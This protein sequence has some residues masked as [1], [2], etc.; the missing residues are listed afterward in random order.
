[1]GLL[2]LQDTYQLKTKDLANGIV[3]GESVGKGLSGQ[4]CFEVGKAAYNS[5]EYYHTLEWMQEALERSKNE[6]PKTVKESE[7]LE[8]LAFAL[9]K[10]G[11]LKRALAMTY[12][13]FE[14]DP[15]HP[16]AEG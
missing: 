16:R 9:Y 7:I 10:Q 11:N 4:D 1:M 3:A 5:K 8:Y 2:R 12:R 14:I 6:K 13:L 15:N